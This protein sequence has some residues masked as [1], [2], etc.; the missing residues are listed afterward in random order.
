[1]NFLV[2]ISKLVKLLAKLWAKLL[3]SELASF[4]RKR[5]VLLVVLSRPA[6]ERKN[7]KVK[8]YCLL[9]SGAGVAKIE[10]LKY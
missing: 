6:P 10:L 4:H 8:R 7:Y 5:V 3:L 1:M 2:T 9:A